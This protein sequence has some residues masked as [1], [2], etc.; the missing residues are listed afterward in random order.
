[1]GTVRKRGRTWRAEVVKKGLRKSATFDTKAQAWSWIEE[2]ELAI[3]SGR[4]RFIAPA[5]ATFRTLMQRYIRE[6]SPAKK[7][8]K[9]ERDRVNARIGSDDDPPDAE[10][11]IDPIA[12]VPLATLC[13]GD[14]ADWRSWGGF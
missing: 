2:T 8:H 5:N 6:V 12:H 7:G 10:R 1:M 13:G 14:V 4:S 9:W 11:Q 3:D